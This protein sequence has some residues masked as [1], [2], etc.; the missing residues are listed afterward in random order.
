MRIQ[1][2]GQLITLDGTGSH[3]LENDPLDSYEWDLNHDGVAEVTGSSLINIAVPGYMSVGND[4][5]YLRWGVRP[6][7]AKR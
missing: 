7:F 1:Q 3:D 5:V 4:T 2:C 6:Y